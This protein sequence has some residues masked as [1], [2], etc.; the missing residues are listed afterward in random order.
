MPC[1]RT[2]A[3]QRPQIRDSNGNLQ[4]IP[5][6]TCNETSAPLAFRYGVTETITCTVDSLTDEDYHML[7]FYVH[8]DVPLSCRMPTTPRLPEGAQP[9]KSAGSKEQA[10]KGGKRSKQQED[11]NDKASGG[12]DA[13]QPNR[14]SDRAPEPVPEPEPVP[15]P[16]TPIIFGLQGALQL[17]HLHLWPNMNVVLHTGR[18]PP[19]SAKDRKKIQKS[20]KAAARAPIGRILAGSAYSLPNVDLGP[21]PGDGKKPTENKAVDLDPWVGDKG[22]KVVIGEPLVFTFHVGW[23]DAREAPALLRHESTRS[24]VASGSSSGSSSSES[25]V[26]WRM[27]TL[28]LVAVAGGMVA[29]WWERNVRRRSGRWREGIL[30]NPHAGVGGA[31]ARGRGSLSNFGIL[32]NDGGVSFGTKGAVNGYGGYGGYGF[33]HGG[34]MFGQGRFGGASKKD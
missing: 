12:G 34:G 5:F 24:G 16:Y 2:T 33:A 19:A 31:A 10:A 29:L 30:G 21:S 4:Y 1:R 6:F 13:A 11:S 26:F 8:S 18:L 7:Q 25:S 32:Q 3:K 17:S 15:D 20:R 23:S 14:A 22:I 28:V 9:P 27:V